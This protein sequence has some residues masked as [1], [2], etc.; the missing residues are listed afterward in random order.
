MATIFPRQ[1]HPTRILFH[2]PADMAVTII[3]GNTF[4][5]NLIAN[6]LLIPVTIIEKPT[7]ID[8]SFY[9]ILNA[10]IGQV[11]FLYQYTWVQGG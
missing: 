9:W 6:E 10:K 1:S 3:I 11:C 7:A 2:C 8:D 4:T 5:C